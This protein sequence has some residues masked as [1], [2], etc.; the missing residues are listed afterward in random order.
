MPAMRPVQAAGAAV[1]SLTGRFGPRCR[2]VL[3]P[4]G[5]SLFVQVEFDGDPGAAALLLRRTGTA[6]LTLPLERRP[7]DPVGTAVAQTEDLAALRPDGHWSVLLR[8]GSSAR[9][10][11]WDGADPVEDVAR[12]SPPDPR[13]G[14]TVTPHADRMGR[15]T[16]QVSGPTPWAQVD[17]VDVRADSLALR[18]RVLAAPDRPARLTAVAD[19][20]RRHDLSVSGETGGWSAAIG[21]ADLPVGDL[22]ARWTLRMSLDDGTDLPVGRPLTDLVALPGVFRYPWAAGPTVEIRPQYTHSRRL[23]LHQR[24]RETDR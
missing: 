13:S 19:D 12:L 20:G 18:G 9:A 4:A 1:R 15:L 11:R 3:V 7:F 17:V 24:H 22:P 23:E 16:L 5:R 10:L 8:S 14:W 2:A 6:D 21:A